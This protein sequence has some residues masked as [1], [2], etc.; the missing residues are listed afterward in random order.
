[1]IRLV[2]IGLIASFAGIGSAVLAMRLPDDLV[3]VDPEPV[4]EE[5]ALPEPFEWDREAT[6]ELFAVNCAVCHG[7]TGHGDGP[8]GAGLDPVPAAFAEPG[9]LPGRSDRYLFWRVS[10]G[11]SLTPMPAFKYGLSPEQRWALIQYL[12]ESWE[13]EALPR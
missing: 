3:V 4:P 7:D 13:T 10:E 5:V 8:G 9:F 1:M 11:K 6:A 2:A 12:R